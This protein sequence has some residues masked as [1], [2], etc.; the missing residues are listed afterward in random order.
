MPL[1][2]LRDLVSVLEEKG[3]LKRVKASVDTDLEIAEIMRRLMYAKD[4]PAVLFENVK[5][6]SI[7]I[8]GNT[9]GSNERLRIALEEDDFSQIGSR[10]V[11]LTRMKMPT[12]VFGK[13][14]MLPK[15]SEISDYGPRHIENGPVKEIVLTEDKA[16][17]FTLPILKSFKGDA[18]KFI[19]F[20]LTVTKHPDTE[21]T[22]MGVYR[23]QILNARK[24]IMHWQI[25]KR[26]A[27]HLEILKDRRSQDNATNIIDGRIEVAVVI[28]ADPAT[29]FSAVAPVPEG[30]DKYLFSGIVRKKGI[31]LVKCNTVDLEVPATA[32]I[33]LEGY[34]DPD[35]MQMEG[36]FGDHTGYYT[37]PEPYPSFNLTCISMRKNPIYL[38]T[39]VGK[40]ILEDAYIGQVIE[41]S[42]LPLIQMFQPEVVDFSMPPAAW[43]Q[44]LAIISIKK[45]YPGQA[46]KV[47]MGLWGM[48]Q[49]SLTKMFIT[50]DHEIN[51]HDMDEVLWAVTTRTDPKR[52]LMIIENAP[53]DTLDPSSPLLNLGSKVGIDATTKWH[54]EGF[55]RDIQIFS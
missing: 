6:Y 9:F 29:T 43:F 23:M 44:G 17:L 24:A 22:N 14:R 53:T 32:E 49:L 38:T 3:Q 30:M 55:N 27:Q 10:I 34:V 45:R 41:R 19:T 1:E 46:K 39:V 50:V 16:D 15:L 36:P 13:L 35:D 21:V 20:G 52:D 18:G 42:F 54:Q 2:S 12:G 37:P 40:P 48:G 5:G 8:L 31:R 26:G 7:P 11:E 47:M 4:K 33:V 28:G 25:H 51:V